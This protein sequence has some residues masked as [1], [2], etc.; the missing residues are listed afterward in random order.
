MQKLLFTVKGNTN[1]G[2]HDGTHYEHLPDPLLS[3]FMLLWF[4][5]MSSDSEVVLPSRSVA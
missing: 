4:K 3:I 2:N 1:M 5:N